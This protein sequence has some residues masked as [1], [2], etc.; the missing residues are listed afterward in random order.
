MCY[1]MIFFFIVVFFV[2][3][4]SLVVQ[5]D[6]IYMLVF[7]NVVIKGYDFVVYFIDQKLVKGLS[8]IIYEW[9]GVEWC[10]VI[11]VN[12]DK[13]VV[14]FECWVFQYGGYCVWVVSQGYI[15][16]IDFKVWI[17]VGEKFY[18]N[19]SLKI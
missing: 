17:V 7:S 12:C 8:R 14:D 5:K 10:F 15:V 9:K 13:F 11:E 3:L 6:E 4:V 16:G 2:L 18:F 19:Y 1:F